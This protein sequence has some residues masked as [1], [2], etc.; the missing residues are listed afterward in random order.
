MHAMGSRQ[1]ADAARANEQRVMLGVAR[2]VDGGAR[3]QYAEHD[4]EVCEPLRRMWEGDRSSFLAF[5]RC[6]KRRGGSWLVPV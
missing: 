6:Q 3:G 4:W 1:Y 5:A 2:L